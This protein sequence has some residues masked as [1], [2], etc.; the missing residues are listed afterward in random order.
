MVYKT[1]V[2]FFMGYFF[3]EQLSFEAF[4]NIN[5]NFCSIQCSNELIF[6][7]QYITVFQQKWQNISSFG[8]LN[9]YL[10]RKVEWHMTSTPD[11]NTTHKIIG[12]V[13]SP[14]YL[15]TPVSTTDIYIRI[16]T[17]WT[18]HIICIKMLWDSPYGRQKR[19]SYVLLNERMGKVVS[20]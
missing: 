8:F 11:T 17:Y 15:T 10:L 3:H 5:N 12:V 4:F 9:G 18:R 6:P 16:A 7:F 14:L 1:S 19:I 20:L 13:G 2:L